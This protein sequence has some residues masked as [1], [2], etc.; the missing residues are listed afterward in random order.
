MVPSKSSETQPQT[1]NMEAIKKTFERCKA[2]KKVSR[3]MHFLTALPRVSNEG[4]F[5]REQ[6]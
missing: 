6:T 2:Q 3:L 4:Q 1:T 5:S